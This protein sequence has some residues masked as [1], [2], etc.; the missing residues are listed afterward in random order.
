MLIKNFSA[1]LMSTPK[2]EMSLVK[3]D[4]IREN[5]PE[6]APERNLSNVS[7]LIEKNKRNEKIAWCKMEN[8][9]KI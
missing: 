3:L 8:F 5:F 1:M 2:A 6:W 7:E 4:K 9:I